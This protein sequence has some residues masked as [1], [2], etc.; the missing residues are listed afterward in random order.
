[1]LELVMPV[2]R[3]SPCALLVTWLA[4]GSVGCVFDTSGVGLPLGGDAR[5]D[6]RL[7]ALRSEAATVHPDGRIEGRVDEH[8]PGREAGSDTSTRDSKPWAPDQGSFKPV[9]SSDLLAT[10]NALKV[11][12]VDNSGTAT[13]AKVSLLDNSGWALLVD[14][15]VT[16][17]GAPQVTKAWVSGKP[18]V[19]VCFDPNSCGDENPRGRGKDWASAGILIRGATLGAGKLVLAPGT[20]TSDMDLINVTDKGVFEDNYDFAEPDDSKLTDTPQLVPTVTA[21]KL[22]ILQA[23]TK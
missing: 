23:A 22:G 2:P 21:L 9:T 7:D 16:L 1:M 19:T 4:A 17:S 6:P 5:P 20:T 13:G 11:D 18:V 3:H 10:W 12:C 8:R 14:G 15:A